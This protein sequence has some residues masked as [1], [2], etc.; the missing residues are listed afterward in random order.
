MLELIGSEYVIDHCLAE[1]Q[2]RFEEKAYRVYTAELLK[3]IAECV[4]VT[5]NKKYTD[6]IDIT[7][8]DTRTGDEVALDV[9]K[10]AGLKVG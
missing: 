6:I 4:G 1:A 2:A 8:P 5:V 9:I 3:T 7:P 10:R